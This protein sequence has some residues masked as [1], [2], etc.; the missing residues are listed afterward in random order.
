MDG[1]RGSGSIQSQ[2]DGSA[3]PSMP[4]TPSDPCFY[5]LRLLAFSLIL[6]GGVRGARREG[7]DPACHHD[8]R[9][10][11]RPLRP[12]QAGHRRRR[13]HRYVCV[14]FFGLVDLQSPA[15]CCS[16]CFLQVLV[17]IISSLYSEPSCSVSARASWHLQPERESQM[18][19]LEGC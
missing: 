6:A 8:E 2:R 17:P 10:Q 4:A 12:L 7:Q 15:C 14:F 19:C 5:G 1:V 3:S 18:G 11:A 13:Q 16:G 9:E